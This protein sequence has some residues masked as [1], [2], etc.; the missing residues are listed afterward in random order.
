MATTKCT[1]CNPLLSYVQAKKLLQVRGENCEIQSSL[2]L[3]LSRITAT[4]TQEGVRFDNL[5]TITWD[6]LKKIAKNNRKCFVIEPDGL[7]EIRVFSE[8]TSWVRTLCPTESAPTTLVSGFPMHR[9]KNTNPWADTEAKVKAADPIRGHVLDTATGLGYTAIQAARKADQLTTIELDPAALELA[10]NN[11]WSQ[12]L[13]TNPKINQLIGD[14]VA[15]L[16]TLPSTE[17]SVILHDPPTKQ[18][19]GELYSLGFYQE[20]RRVLKRQGRLFHYIGDP[21]SG[22]GASMTEGVIRRLKE[23]GFQ[24]VDRHPEAFGVTAYSNR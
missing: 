21:A 8:T 9:I 16:P 19:A 18:F 2:D 4:V 7:R 6:E 23:A 10:S 22:L 3:E 5:R 20:L 14:A 24:R 15:L 11:P 17:F 13:F 1:G 12:E